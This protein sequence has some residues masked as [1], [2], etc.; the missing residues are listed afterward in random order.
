LVKGQKGA[1]KHRGNDCDFDKRKKERD[2]FDEIKGDKKMSK[3]L[4]GRKKKIAKVQGLG[5]G[6]AEREVSNVE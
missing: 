5:V 4:G 2:L 6:P 3:K 1:T